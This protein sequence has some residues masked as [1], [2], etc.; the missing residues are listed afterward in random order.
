VADAGRWLAETWDGL[1]AADPVANPEVFVAAVR[2]YAAALVLAGRD[3]ERFGIQRALY[4]WAKEPWEFEQAALGIA[5][6]LR[7]K[8]ENLLRANA[9]LAFQQHGPAG[10]DPLAGESW[11]LPEGWMRYW[12]ER[13]DAANA[14]GDLPGETRFRLLAGDLATALQLTR[15]AKTLLSFDEAALREHVVLASMTLKALANHPGLGA[16]YALFLE[17]GPRGPDGTLNLTDPIAAD[18]AI[19]IPVPGSE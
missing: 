18:F 12:R 17:Y 1:L 11:V 14:A 10:S 13:A 5:G 16:T 6:A 2:D 3:D 19:V 15:R 8:D 7:A 4:A 9:W